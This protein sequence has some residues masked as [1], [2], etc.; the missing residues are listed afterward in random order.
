MKALYLIAFGCTGLLPIAQAQTTN[1]D[2]SNNQMT[3]TL[4]SDGQVTSAEYPKGSGKQAGGAIELW[5]AASS[6]AGDTLL[7]Y[8]H[9]DEY[10]SH[11]EP[12]LYLPDGSVNSAISAS[13]FDKPAFVS[14]TEIMEHLT[15]YATSRNILEWPASGNADLGLPI[16]ELAPFVDLNNNQVY[17]PTQGEYPDIK[18][19][20]AAWQVIHEKDPSASSSLHAEVQITTYLYDNELYNQQYFVDYKLINHSDGAWIDTRLGL[21]LALDLGNPFDDYVASAS[22]VESVFLYNGDANDELR[23]GYGSTSDIPAVSYSLFESPINQNGEVEL[24]SFVSYKNDHSNMGE[25]ISKREHYNYMLGL[26]K[27]GTPLRFGRDGMS[28]SYDYPIMFDLSKSN[29]SW[30]ECSSQNVPGERR[31]V[32]S[33][34]PHTIYPGESA[35]YTI[36]AQMHHNPQGFDCDNIAS[37]KNSVA[38]SRSN[39][40]ETLNCSGFPPAFQIYT[41]KAIGGQLGSAEIKFYS[42]IEPR[43]VWS[44]GSTSNTIDQLEAG[45]QKVAIYWPDCMEVIEVEIIGQS[46]GIGEDEASEWRIFPNPSSGI[47]GVTQAPFVDQI[48]IYDMQG[49]LV[50]ESRMVQ[51][52]M[53]IEHLPSGFYIVKGYRKDGQ[54]D[55]KRLEVL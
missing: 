41:T 22:S 18:G 10:R 50:F 32:M 29:G 7:S 47:I 45:L 17:E 43:V 5:L 24:A 30:T 9:I 19:D 35:S 55:T 42:S 40:D 52:S 15:G 25:P 14:R 27:D 4:R 54:V 46:T 49:R 11:F 21:N 1:H 16:R 34:G 13:L 53:S 38:N 6:L 39:W 51:A 48:R 31:G 2:I 37:L 3:L 8:Q 23:V 12:G 28:G 33:F 20:Y 36:A 44:N 26:W